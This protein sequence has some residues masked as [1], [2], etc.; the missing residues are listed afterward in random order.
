MVGGRLQRLV[1]GGGLS[2]IED[3]K[4]NGV[5]WMG[6]CWRNGLRGENFCETSVLGEMMM[7]RIFKTCRAGRER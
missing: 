5:A 3:L 6:G 7:M 2:L 4:G 1:V